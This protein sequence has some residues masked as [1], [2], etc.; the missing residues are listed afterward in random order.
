MILGGSPVLGSPVFS[1]SREIREHKEIEDILKEARSEVG[2]GLTRGVCQI[3]W[4]EEFMF[5]GSEIEHEAFLSLWLE[6][7]V[8]HDSENTLRDCIFPIAIHL[9][10][11]ELVALAPAVLASIYRDLGLLKAQIVAVTEFRRRDYADILAVALWS[12][13]HL[14]QL[15]AWERFPAFQPRASS[16]RNGEP[17]SALWDKVKSRKVENVR[18]V[19]DS[20]TETFRWRPYATGRYSFEFYKEKEEWRELGSN[21]D[22]LSFALCLRV[23]ELVGIGCIERYL[24]HRVARQFGFDQDIPCDIAKSNGIPELAWINYIRPF[25]VTKLLVPSPFFV[26]DFT[27]KY[28]RWWKQSGLDSHDLLKNAIIAAVRRKRSSRKR[29]KGLPKAWIGKK[30]DNNAGIVPS[31]S[32][33]KA[34]NGA[35]SEVKSLQKP[36]ECIM[37]LNTEIGRPVRALENQAGIPACHTPSK[38]RGGGENNVFEVPGLAL[39]SRIAILEKAIAELKGARFGSRFEKICS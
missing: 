6:M 22:L 32:N 2:R 27:I 33:A 34:N 24:P 16:I 4:M 29:S 36:V 35:L 10:E 7:F 5:S 21:Q 8:F 14:V 25:S 20:A 39:E 31:P 9:A 1:C 19:L 18:F 3:G 37:N 12:P 17:R 23:S 30:G 11:G 38:S 28:L 26:P 15:W 13:L